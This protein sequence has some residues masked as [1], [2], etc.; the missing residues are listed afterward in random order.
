[1]PLLWDLV[2]EQTMN[3]HTST[4]RAGHVFMVSTRAAGAGRTSLPV[5]V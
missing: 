5:S 3:E 2:S 4:I 1:M